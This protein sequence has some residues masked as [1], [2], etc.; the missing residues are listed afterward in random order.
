MFELGFGKSIN[1]IDQNLA[2]SLETG[3]VDFGITEKISS[4]FSENRDDSAYIRV[5]IQALNGRKKLRQTPEVVVVV[6]NGRKDVDLI[7]Q[8]FLLPNELIIGQRQLHF[9]VKA[10]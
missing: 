7:I 5:A 3:V 6:V 1:L 8:V 9:L 4:L 10:A 2:A